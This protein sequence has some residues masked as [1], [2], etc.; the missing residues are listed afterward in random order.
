MESSCSNQSGPLSSSSVPTLE[1]GCDS[2]MYGGGGLSHDHCYTWEYDNHHLE[3]FPDIHHLEAVNIL[4][5]YMTLANTLAPQPARIL[6]WTDNM[7]SAWALMSGRT[8]D[9]IL[10]ACARQLWLYGSTT[11]H[12]IE[13]HHKKGTDI[14]TADALSRMAKDANKACFVQYNIIHSNLKMLKPVLNNHV[15]CHPHL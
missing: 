7:A 3:K 13:I 6:I 2:S 4:V 5:A 15:F 10:G 11:S 14:P 8:K 1:L 12:E 9:P